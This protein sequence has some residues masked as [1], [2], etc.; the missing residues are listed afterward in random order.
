MTENGT[1]SLVDASALRCIST[2]SESPEAVKG[3]T[4][5]AM[6]TGGAA[7]LLGIHGGIAAW[8]ASSPSEAHASLRRDEIPGSFTRN[9]LNLSRAICQQEPWST[10][11]MFAEDAKDQRIWNPTQV[12]GVSADRLVELDAAITLSV[13]AEDFD[14]AP[15]KFKVDSLAAKIK[16]AALKLGIKEHIEPDSSL[17]QRVIA[18]GVNSWVRTH[19]SYNNA[20]LEDETSLPHATLAL[21][22]TS[23]TLLQQRQCFAICGGFARLTHDLSIA[24]GLSSHLM[25]GVIRDDG[26]RIPSRRNHAWVQHEF[27]SKDG[28]ASFFCSSDNTIGRINIKKAP[29]LKGKIHSPCCLPAYPM[30][31]GYYLWREHALGV[32]GISEKSVPENLK[33]QRCTEQEWRQVDRCGPESLLAKME[34]NMAGATVD[35]KPL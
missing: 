5:K 27:P 19:I 14:Y 7:I 32:D 8:L 4:R 24:A 15:K 6:V 16:E 3:S 10:F 21:Y 9:Q 11:R 35:I 12:F 23:E 18:A 20:L 29:E 31:W 2:V 17:A 30:D 34:E 1:I 26:N 13:I 33:L 25:L 22:W 28:N